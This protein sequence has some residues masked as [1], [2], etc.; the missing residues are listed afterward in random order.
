MSSGSSRIV[1][2]EEDLEQSGEGEVW[3]IE[4]KNEIL[5]EVNRSLGVSKGP[6]LEYIF[7]DVFGVARLPWP[8]N[9][10]AVAANPYGHAAVRYRLDDE[11]YVMNITGTE[12]QPMVGF[13]APQEYIFGRSAEQRGIYTRNMYGV[14]VENVE[15]ERILFMHQYYQK[16]AYLGSKK[17]AKFSLIFAKI[18]NLL[19]GWL[20]IS[21]SE[22]G[23]CAWWTSGGLTEAGMLSGQN[24]WPKSIFVQI[25]EEQKLANPDNVHVV[26]YARVEELEPEYGVGGYVGNPGVKPFSTVA[27]VLYRNLGRFAD[28]TVEVPPGERRAVVTVNEQPDGASWMRLNW[29]KLSSTVVV[30]ALGLRWGYRRYWRPPPPPAAESRLELLQNQVIRARMKYLQLTELVKVK[31]EELNNKPPTTS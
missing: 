5:D 26:K 13:F 4:N 2:I 30:T 11:E 15:R 16:V 6:D 23:N 20:P 10:F 28:V 17:E 8:L 19:R 12:G 31:L 3:E 9:Q 24:L 18:Y 1:A 29:W 22:R 21:I 7:V 25:F 27:N 14:R